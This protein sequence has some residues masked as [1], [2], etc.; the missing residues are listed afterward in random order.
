VGIVRLFRWEGTG[1]Y[2]IH[3]LITKEGKKECKHRFP[4]HEWRVF[5]H[6][7]KFILCSQSE[8]VFRVESLLV[9]HG[10]QH[11]QTQLQKWKWRK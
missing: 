4:E 5:V 11:I 1:Q 9:L 2:C 8:C 3:S 10:H 6:L 7:K